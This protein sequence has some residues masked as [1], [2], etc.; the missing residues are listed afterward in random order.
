MLKN[1]NLAAAILHYILAIGF[2][3]YYT[4]LNNKYPNENSVI[5]VKLKE[6]SVNPNI[7]II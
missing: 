2:S 6:S 4:Y 1:L 3:A 7:R 5:F